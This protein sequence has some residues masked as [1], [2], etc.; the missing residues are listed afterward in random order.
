MPSRAAI[1]SPS[2]RE[3]LTKP[4]D[5]L[6]HLPHAEHVN[7]RPLLYHSAVDEMNRGDREARA[8]S[9]VARGVTLRATESIYI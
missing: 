8:K 4:A 3:K 5:P 7:L 6:Q 2:A 1:C 9:V